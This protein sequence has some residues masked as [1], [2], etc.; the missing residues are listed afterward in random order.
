MDLRNI[1]VSSMFPSISLFFDINK[2]KDTDGSI[3]PEPSRYVWLKDKTK[4][5]DV[6]D[7]FIRAKFNIP[8]ECKMVFSLYTPPENKQKKLVI[9]KSTNKLISR[10]LISTISESPELDF[11]KKTETMKMRTNDA[12]NIP[13]PVNSMMTIEFDNSKTLII[14]A[15]KGFRQQRM[16]KRVENR[17]VMMFD[18]VYTDDIKEAIKDL[19]GKD[20][21]L[22][23]YDR[24]DTGDEKQG[25]EGGMQTDTV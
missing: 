11:G 3:N 8:V 4:S 2:F 12:Y 18:Y 1:N 16:T 20:E 6:L 7:K 9:K 22:R 25:N 10:V 14:P 15:R 19:T 24:P 17:Y 5:I 13:Y 21:E 23:G